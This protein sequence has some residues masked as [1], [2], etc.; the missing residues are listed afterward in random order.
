MLPIKMEAIMS[1]MKNNAFLFLV[2]LLLGCYQ[3]EDD[4][5]AKV[6]DPLD[7]EEDENQTVVWDEC[8]PGEEEFYRMKSGDECSFL[9]GCGLTNDNDDDAALLAREVRCLDDVLSV[10]NAKRIL[11]ADP[12][13]DLLWQNCAALNDG[14]IGER[15]EG[16]FVC[17]KD[18][19]DGCLDTVA[20]V[21]TPIPPYT[22][23]MIVRYLLCDDAGASAALTNTVYTNCEDATSAH[24]LDTCDSS[25]LC[26][27]KIVD[28]TDSIT[29]AIESIP[30]C[31]E[32]AGFCHI[33]APDIP[34]ELIWC[35]GRT[36]HILTDHDQG[37]TFL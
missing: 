1:L 11:K 25:F 7:E 34:G 19:S 14:R 35:D 21:T 20:C 33:G 2:V 29:E 8:Q 3:L 22:T 31:S 36:V 24:A 12:R 18:A 32:Q 5:K 17:Y 16:D 13:M 6:L 26:E 9:A 37:R 10:T 4:S 15:C 27:K 28:A 30:P 23:K